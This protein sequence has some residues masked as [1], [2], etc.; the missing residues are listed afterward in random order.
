MRACE[1]MQN[2]RNFIN[3]FSSP[4]WVSLKDFP[5]IFHFLDLLLPFSLKQ[6]TQNQL[7]G[8][9]KIMGRKLK[10][11]LFIYFLPSAHLLQFFQLH[12]SRSF[13]KQNAF[14]TFPFWFTLMMIL[15]ELMR[16]SVRY[17]FPNKS[18]C[19]WFPWACVRLLHSTTIP[20]AWE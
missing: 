3:K 4:R 12:H 15:D 13:P 5:I 6:G 18:Y 17:N 14:K 16:L 10:V 7:W 19:V 11:L 20:Y 8:I 2:R 1:R 9:L